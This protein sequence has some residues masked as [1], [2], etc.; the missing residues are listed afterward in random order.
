MYFAWARSKGKVYFYFQIFQCCAIFAKVCWIAANTLYINSS[1]FSSEMAK[2]LSICHQVFSIPFAA[3]SVTTQPFLLLNR[4]QIVRLEFLNGLVMQGYVP[5]VL[6]AI[7][8]PRSIFTI[9][10]HK[11]TST[12]NQLTL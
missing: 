12:I 9:Y 5:F 11:P 2:G 4:V 8:W 7:K 3:I 6:T 1:C 10:L